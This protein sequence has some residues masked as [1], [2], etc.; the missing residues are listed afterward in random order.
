MFNP[1]PEESI[2][3]TATKLTSFV[4]GT[5]PGV[6]VGEERYVVTR[7]V[8]DAIVEVVSRVQ[9]PVNNRGHEC[10]EGW[11]GTWTECDTA[12]D[13]YS[14]GLMKALAVKP[15]YDWDYDL[16]RP[17]STPFGYEISWG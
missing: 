8:G 2:M 3:T 14:H 10:A 13:R 4:Y 12:A 5:P 6:E 17:K 9:V 11:L 7:N 1:A 16:D 15:E